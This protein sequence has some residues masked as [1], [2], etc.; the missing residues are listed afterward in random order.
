MG[1]FEKLMLVLAAIGAIN[2][3]FYVLNFDLIQKL[4]VSWAG[5]LVG[6]IIYVV[7]ALCG[8][9]ALVKIFSK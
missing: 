3:G 9:Y 4:I 8:I 6:Q 1:G 7:V 2:W 5:T